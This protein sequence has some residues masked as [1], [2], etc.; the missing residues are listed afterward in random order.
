MRCGGSASTVRT[1]G[2]P[3]PAATRYMLRGCC[4]GC[5]TTL[6]PVSSSPTP[7]QGNLKGPEGSRHLHT[8]TPA[9]T[10]TPSQLAQLSLEEALSE[11]VLTPART[12]PLLP[13]ATSRV[14]ASSRHRPCPYYDSAPLAEPTR[15]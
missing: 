1:D 3:P 7:P 14:P 12:A 15:G 2:D 4:G 6:T 10:M 5:S 11:C 8:A 9:L 13:R